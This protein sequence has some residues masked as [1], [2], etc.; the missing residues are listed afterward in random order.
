MKKPSNLKDLQIRK[1]PFCDVILEFLDVL[2]KDLPELIIENA[3]KEL[4]EGERP[5]LKR[6]V[7]SS[8]F[9]QI[10]SAE[11]E[12]KRKYMKVYF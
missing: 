6:I 8:V 1:R 9:S 12:R 2:N 5:K 10:D 11:T 7:G 3:N 4:N